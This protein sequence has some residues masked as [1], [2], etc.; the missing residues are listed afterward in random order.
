VHPFTRTNIVSVA[1]PKSDFQTSVNV[2]RVKKNYRQ[3]QQ[4]NIKKTTQQA[5]PHCKYRRLPYD[6]HRHPDYWMYPVNV[7]FAERWAT[8]VTIPLAT[9]CMTFRNNATKFVA[10]HKNW[11][12]F[13]PAHAQDKHRINLCYSLNTVRRGDSST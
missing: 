10:R 7:T 11:K 4:L 13:G 1:A 12:S 8:H 3:P 2:E 5:N 9:K 6:K